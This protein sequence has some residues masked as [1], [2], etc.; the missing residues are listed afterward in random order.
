MSNT[1]EVH[2]RPQ[3]AKVITFKSYLAIGLGIV[4]G[5]GWVVYAGEWLAAGGPLGAAI[6]F[7][8]GGLLLIPIGKCYGEMTSAM[9]V[10]GG[11]LAFAYR[12]F[13]T[14][15]AFLTAWMLALS[16][17]SIT[18]F[19]TIAIGTLFEAVVPSLVTEA[20]YEVG[21]SKVSL[22]TAIPGLAIGVFLIWLNYAGASHS[23]RIQKYIL[24]AMLLCTL[25]FTGLVLVKGDMSNLEPFFA[26]EGHLW[27]IVPASI[28]SV[29]VVVPFFIAGFDAI[30]QAAE[31]AGFRMEPRK[32][33]T[34][35]IGT[36]VGATVFYVLIILAVS[37]AMPWRETAELSLPTAE[38][39]R[40]AFG[41]EWAAKL[42]LIT[43]MLGLI[44]TLNGVYIAA[45][46]LLFALGRGGLLP[47]WFATVHPVH[48]TPRNAI[49][50]VGAVS[51][52]GP[53]V[54]KAA[55]GPIVSSSSLG[56]ACAYTV[57]CLSAIRLRA[58]EPALHRPY[59]V[60]KS[61]LY[62]GAVV[63]ALFVLLMVLPQSP[64]QLSPIEFTFV[65]IWLVFGYLAFVWRQ[66]QA[67]LTRDERDLMILGEYR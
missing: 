17:V 9:P 11:E 4:L 52:I 58:T 19:E 63:S 53:F 35:I 46:R 13:G 15:P 10:A 31:E 59:R 5:V 16:Y 55:M 42:V 28:V 25:V 40:V 64:G 60:N 8:L 12:A 61:T 37:L 45:S 2:G 44:S 51:L 36:I 54:G 24:Y 33:G 50:F 32:L 21:G 65:G 62:A 22:S 7:L 23:V 57:T 30:P 41:Y 29:L 34:A 67:E 6:A 38:V 56:F 18:P 39:F 1:S 43:A 66:R 48:H 3:L 20:L 49:L 27:A 26:G 47:N 14:L